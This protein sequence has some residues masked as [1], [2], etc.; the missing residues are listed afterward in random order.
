M[1]TTEESTP[2]L[3]FIVP[4]IN[5]RKELEPLKI[6]GEFAE[7]GNEVKV[8]DEDCEILTESES[9]I[10]CKLEHQKAHHHQFV[11]V[12]TPNLGKNYFFILQS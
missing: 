2:D 7:V 5:Q 10:I 3:H 9:E 8:G 12:K 1:K 6:Y 11:Q 4:H